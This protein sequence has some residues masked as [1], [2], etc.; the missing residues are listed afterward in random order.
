MGGRLHL[1]LDG[2]G[3]AVLGGRARPL[4]T[5]SSR[6]VDECDNDR[7]PARCRLMAPDTGQHASH[8]LTSIAKEPRK[9]NPQAEVP[10]CPGVEWSEQL[11]VGFF[12][13]PRMNPP[14]RG[15]FGFP[16]RGLEHKPLGS[17]Y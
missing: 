1:H 5:Q 9:I 11:D 17:A 13:R 8:L 16:T 2:R 7:L 3:L 14:V 4:L 12:I 15:P 6:L 10:Q